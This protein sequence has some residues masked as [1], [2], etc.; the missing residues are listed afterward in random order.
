[1]RNASYGLRAWLIAAVIV[2][3]IGW[4]M[5]LAQGKK[6]PGGPK[7]KPGSSRVFESEGMRG[8]TV[9]FLNPVTLR[10]VPGP[11]QPWALDRGEVKIEKTSAE[12]VYRL[13]VEV[14]GLV[15]DPVTSTSP[16]AGTNPVAN[17]RAIVSCVDKP[18]GTVT[19]VTSNLFPANLAGDAELAELMNL[20]DPCMAIVVFVTSPAGNWFAVTGF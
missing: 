2:L 17:F 5:G 1:M 14:R 4:G 19:N 10:G 18:D 16:A 9:D 11:G 15:L 8:V 3:L 6:G 12:N 7:P 20:P 13:R